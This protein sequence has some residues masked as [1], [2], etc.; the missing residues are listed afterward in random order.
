MPPPPFWLSEG[1]K[2]AKN[3]LQA[4]WAPHYFASWDMANKIAVVLG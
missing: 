3:L 2:R 4:N 1:V